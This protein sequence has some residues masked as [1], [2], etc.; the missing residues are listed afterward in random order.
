MASL[1]LDDK[2]KIPKEQIL[3]GD[4]TVDI[5][6]CEG[7]VVTVHGLMAND[8]YIRKL[9]NSVVPLVQ[10]IAGAVSTPDVGNVIVVDS[11]G[12]SFTL[13]QIADGLP[14]VHEF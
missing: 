4:K 1:I 8:M 6:D 5:V 2:D 11:S 10:Y 3:L 9:D 12:N 14:F 7:N 13:Q